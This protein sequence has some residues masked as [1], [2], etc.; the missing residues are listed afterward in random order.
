MIF[1]NIFSGEGYNKIIS[2]S[3]TSS[4][5]IDVEDVEIG[6]SKGVGRFENKN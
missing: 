1:K 5:G 6:W 3:S 4:I 2:G